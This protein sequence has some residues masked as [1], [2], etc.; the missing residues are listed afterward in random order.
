LCLAF[1]LPLS[2]LCLAFVLPLSCA[3]ALEKSAL[4]LLAAGNTA[5]LPSLSYFIRRS[6]CSSPFCQQACAFFK[7]KTGSP[8]C[9]EMQLF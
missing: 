5:Q 9:R 1:V 6:L 4:R 8:R 3:S 7:S 2:C